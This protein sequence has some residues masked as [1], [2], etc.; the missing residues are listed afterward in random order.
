MHHILGPI[1]PYGETGVAMM[2]GDGVWRRCHPI[3]AI[4]VGDYPEQAL[5]AC[6]YNSRCPKCT[7]SPGQLGEDE[8]FPPRVQSMAIDTFRLAD[9]NIR[10]F[11]VVCHK[12]GL[13]AVV[14]P[15]WETLP[16]V[17]IFVSITPDILHQLL[18]RMM[19]HLVQWVTNI[20][21]AAGVDAQCHV[22]PPNHRTMLFTKGI[23]TL[24]H[25]TGQ[26]HKKMCAILL[27]LIVD[28]SVPG[29]HDPSRILK[30][31]RSLLNFLYLAQYQCH[32]SESIT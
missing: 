21:G 10:G 4:F 32:T 31:V 20:F 22:I 17:D 12:S 28:L 26:E 1:K 30:A 19:K 11:H 14:H 23:S 5:V 29:G 13:K 7:V 9:S 3:F 27:G 16:L 18:Q 2:S 24:S 8:M 25:V 15:F 6:T